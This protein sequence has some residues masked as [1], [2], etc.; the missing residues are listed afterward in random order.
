M[1]N[2]ILIAS[3]A[4]PAFAGGSFVT[5]SCD[6]LNKNM[7][8][9]TTIDVRYPGDYQRGHIK[10][11]VSL[12][13]YDLKKISYPKNQAL[14]VYCSGIGCS[15]SHDAAIVLQELGYTNV[16]VL[17]GGIAE[18]SMKGYPI[19]TD[20]NAPSTIKTSYYFPQWAVFQGTE[21]APKDYWAKASAG[22]K[23][24]LIDTRPA[25]EYAAGHLP[26]AHNLAAEDLAGKLP[27]LSKTAEY[28][29]Y[30]RRPERSRTVA[31]KMR[32]A[33]LPAHL[34]VGGVSVWTAAGLPM[35]VAPDDAK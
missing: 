5:V 12:P 19:V 8:A 3:L 13:Y 16:K 1:K 6:D 21:V 14:A 24:Y 11:A 30:D 33:G 31:Q 25:K 7:A 34:L 10:G 18:W 35:S 26:G 9:T 4:S 2:L 29:V 32:D 22:G 28:V 27:S 20:P 15:L 23:F 17:E